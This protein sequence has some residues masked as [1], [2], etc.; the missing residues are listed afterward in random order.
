MRLEV[1]VEEGDAIVGLRLWPP[2]GGEADDRPNTTCSA[3]S[4]KIAYPSPGYDCEFKDQISAS[5]KCLHIERF[6]DHHSSGCHGS[7]YV[8]V[9]R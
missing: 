1:V 5:E 2:R 3:L 8:F 6:T 9:R 7:S 4:Y